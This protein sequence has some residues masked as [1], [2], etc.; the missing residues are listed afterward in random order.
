MQVGKDTCDCV[1]RE[2]KSSF[3][4]RWFGCPREDASSALLRT[5][6]ARGVSCGLPLQYPD[7]TLARRSGNQPEVWSYVFH[8][9]P[10]LPSCG[11]LTSAHCTPLTGEREGWT[12][13]LSAK[14]QLFM[15]YLFQTHLSYREHSEKVMTPD[16]FL[17][18]VF[19]MHIN[20]TQVLI[21][22]NKLSFNTPAPV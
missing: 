3:T 20:I 22:F 19:I 6:P 15:Y 18:Y 21:I 17:S 11:F 4:L 5:P 14:P 9:P 13:S 12:G 8:E 2:R 1:G 7:R 10:V 16:Q